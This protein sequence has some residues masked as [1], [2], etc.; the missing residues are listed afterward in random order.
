MFIQVSI[1]CRAVGARLPVQAYTMRK[2]G[3]FLALLIM[4]FSLAGCALGGTSGEPA[5]LPTIDSAL[6]SVTAPPTST[7]L[8][9]YTPFPTALR[10]PTDTPY[11]T[12]PPRSVPTATPEPVQ[13]AVSGGGAQ[14]PTG[15]STPSAGGYVGIQDVSAPVPELEPI[16]Q[17]LSTNV[18]CNQPMLVQIGVTNWGSAPAYN[19]TIEWSAGLPI[20]EGVERIEEL[21]WGDLPLYL[22]NKEIRFPCEETTTYTAYVRVDVNN[23]VPELYEDNNSVELTFTI[24]YAPPTPTPLP[25][26]TPDPDE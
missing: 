11:P 6:L 8:P 26:S 23:E 9:T 5:P 24:P 15:P 13:P 25:T 20:D 10:L 3:G 21:Q 4:L 16:L 19:F 22:R 14:Q 2:L 7:P 18:V 12:F 17:I 1:L